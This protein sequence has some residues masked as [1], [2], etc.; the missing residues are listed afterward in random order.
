MNLLM[1]QSGALR[2]LLAG[3]PQSFGRNRTTS[4]M[5]T[6]AGKQPVGRF[7]PEPTPVEAQGIEQL[8]AEHDIAILA[9][10]TSPDMDEHPL[11][12]DIADLSVGHLR[13][14]CASGI[15]RH[16]QDAMKGDSCCI[17]QTSDLFWAEY[18]REMQNLFRI[19][20]LGDAPASLQHLDIKEA[21]GCQPLGDGVWSQLPSREQQ[22]LI[23][24][25]M[26]WAKLIGWT[27]KVFTELLDGTDAGI[28][29]GFSVVAAFQFL[30]HHPA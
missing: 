2:G 11:A 30:K 17:D 4:G 21:Q 24:T 13:A 1:L 20:R 15:K 23:L 12:V 7:A 14:A 25:Y 8:G 5:R 9:S 22:S 10:L 28:D 29:G 27:M 16:E 6:V 3:M 19:G 26:L 18:L